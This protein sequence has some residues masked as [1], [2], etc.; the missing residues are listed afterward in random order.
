MD[1]LN[2]RVAEKIMGWANIVCKYDAQN[3]SYFVGENNIGIRCRIPRYTEYNDAAF[4]VVDKMRKNGYGF[5]AVTQY[6]TERW[7]AYFLD[8]HGEPISRSFDMNLSKAICF[9]AI[10]VMEGENERRV[11]EM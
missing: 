4:L 11:E 2:M 7:G 6:G 10:M 3:Y 1:E 5:K 8:E 9:A